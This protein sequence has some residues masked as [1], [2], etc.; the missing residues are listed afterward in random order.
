MTT[1]IKCIDLTHRLD[2]PRW[3]LRPQLCEVCKG[4]GHVQIPVQLGPN[5]IHIVRQPCQACS[6]G[7][8]TIYVSWN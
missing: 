8:Y 5:I 1:I 4:E 7:G 2:A 6:T 3:L